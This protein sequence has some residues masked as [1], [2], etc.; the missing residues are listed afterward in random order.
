MKTAV[1]T[2]CCGFIGREVTIKF[3]ENNWHVYGIDKL[4][5]AADPNVPDQLIKKF[6]DNFKFSRE[7]ISELEWLPDCDVVINIAAESHVTNSIDSTNEFLKSNVLGTQ[8]IIDLICRKHRMTNDAP[9]LFQFSTDE[10]YGDAITGSYNEESQLKPSNPYSASKA[11]ADLLV[12]AAARTHGL[13]YNILR[14]TNNYGNYQY[15]EKLIPL[16]VRNLMRGKTIKLHDMGQPIR[17]WLNVSDTAG[18]VMFI[19]NFAKRN[20]IFNVSSQYEQRNLDIV[21]MV[22]NSFFNGSYLE[23]YKD[24]KNHIDLGHKRPGQ[25]VRY[26][27][28]DSKIRSVGW[29][30][31]HSFE[32]TIDK[33]VQNLKNS[34]RW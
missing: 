23:E 8:K 28:D 6:G 21:K 12:F 7:D 18:A 4:T 24:W 34:T 5:Y 26:S 9:Y 11:S 2:G 31:Q 15:H 1:I 22:I 10:V 30:E 19:H 20:E 16:A 25:D 32:S 29:K 27:I 14:P 3:L 13:K 33:I 17:T